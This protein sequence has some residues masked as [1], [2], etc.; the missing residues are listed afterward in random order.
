MVT[1]KLLRTKYQF[2][3]KM[4]IQSVLIEFCIL[5]IPDSNLNVMAE[6]IKMTG[7]LFMWNLEL[8]I[9]SDVL[10]GIR[11]KQQRMVDPT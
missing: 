7:F 5:R 9:G 3:I 2:T 6:P 10:D 1:V 4:I 11:V 8:V